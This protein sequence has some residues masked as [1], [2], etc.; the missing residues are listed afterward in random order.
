MWAYN[1]NIDGVDVTSY[2]VVIPDLEEDLV[3]YKL[4]EDMYAIDE[5]EML[6]R[7]SLRIDKQFL[8]TNPYDESG[9]EFC[10]YVK[11]IREQIPTEHMHGFM[12]IDSF[13]IAVEDLEEVCSLTPNLRKCS[14]YEQ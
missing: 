2:V 8:L 9:R 1:T 6:D 7:V 5:E 12:Q 11:Q 14:S 4:D 13:I 3:T 10:I